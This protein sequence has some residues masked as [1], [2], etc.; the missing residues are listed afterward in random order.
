MSRVRQADQRRLARPRE[1]HHDEDLAGRH[2]ERD[3]LDAD[4]A[5]GL[6]LEGRAGQVGLRCPDDPV[7]PFAEDLP[8]V[9]DRQGAVDGSGCHVDSW[10]RGS[11]GG[12]RGLVAM[13]VPGGVCRRQ[14]RVARDQ[15][16]GLLGDHHHRSVDVAVGDEREDRGVDDAQALDAVHRHRGRVDDRQLLDAHRGRARRVQR[17]LGVRAHPV[18]DL[19]VGL[20][21]LAGRE[22]AVVE[23]REG[24]LAEDVARHPDRLDP[25][26]LVVVGRQV[27]EQHRG[28]GL[29]VRAPDP[30]VTAGVGIHRTDVHLIAVA[31]GRGRAV[32]P[33]RDRQEVE[34]QVGVV[35]VL[36]AAREPAALEVVG[37]TEATA[38]E[39]PL[40]GDPGP[41]APLET[42]RDRDRLLRGVLDIDLE[43][44]LQVLPHPGRVVD[45]VDAESTEQR[46]VA[47][48]GQLE[49]LRG[50]DRAAAQDHRR[51]RPPCGGGRPCDSR[52]RP[53]ACPRTAPWW[54]A[55]G[56]RHRG[57]CGAGPGADRPAPPRAAGRGAGCGR[58]AQ[59][60]PAGSR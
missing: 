30:H 44:V 12:W 50:V 49:Q 5:A 36:V 14:R 1:T 54:P 15:V 41:F 47:D 17:G 46:L 8:E 34:H 28:V 32:V 4:D 18:E 16:S 27:V 7:G 23:R 55:P 37:G 22:L 13:P 6:L 48:T 39:Q 51:R 42:G 38:V 9:A 59:S 20:D 58:T 40:V 52:R 19:L 10:L 57:S 45:H 3:V 29:R 43:V 26:P 25:L 53:R 21:L 2:V 24:G 56:S 60:P 11:P 31:L 33:D 35:D